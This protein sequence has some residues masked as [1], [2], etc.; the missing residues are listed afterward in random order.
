MRTI[1]EYID[2]GLSINKNTKFRKMGDYDDTDAKYKMTKKN[3][4]KYLWAQWWEY[5]MDKGPMSKVDLLSDFNLAVTSYSTEF[6]KLSKRN[7]IVP[8]KKTRKLE[9]RDISEWV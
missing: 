9:A 1:S 2:E 3:G 8:N 4:E 5:L 7:I 6:A